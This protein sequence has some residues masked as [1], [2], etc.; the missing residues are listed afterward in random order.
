MQAVI[1]AAGR[2][3]RLH[4]ITLKRSKAML[5][6]LGKPIIERVM[7][8]IADNG[9]QDFILVVSPLDGDIVRHFE[10]DSGLE[11]SIRFVTQLRRAGMAD[12]LNYAAPLIEGDFV[13]SACDNLV[14]SEDVGRLLQRW[15][16]AQTLSGL[17]TVMQAPPEALSRAGVVL[18]QGERVLRIVEKP[19][20]GEAPSN[21]ISPPLYCFSPEILGCLQEVRPSPRGE[22][23][24][25][26]AIQM[27][28]DRGKRVDGFEIAQRLALTTAADLL[29]INRQYLQHEQ[30]SRVKL[31]SIGMGSRLIEPVYIEARV[32]IGSGCTIGPEVYIERDCQIG[33]EVKIREAVLLRG[34][35]VGA[36]E[37]ISEQVVG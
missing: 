3:S 15:E 18:L 6:I 2:G 25:Q 4:P 35:V 20:P 33:D 17:I 5:P 36:G 27:L 30:P 9:V 23:E 12:A 13:L 1:L 8:T 24:L 37:V 32:R 29:A 34:S 19:S 22:Y 10:E 16:Q 21:T 31:Q 14:S 28:I 7:E 11:G 26:D